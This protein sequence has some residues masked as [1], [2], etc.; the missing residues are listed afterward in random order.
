MNP[1]QQISNGGNLPWDNIQPWEWQWPLEAIVWAFGIGIGLLIWFAIA[2]LK[3]RK[4]P[5]NFLGRN[6]EDFA[7]QTAE[8]NGKVPVYMML[9]I[10]AYFIFLLFYT[11]IYFFFGYTY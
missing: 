10:A 9:V 5:A 1:E 2:S 11:G 6:V 3:Y 8:A 4:H 7:G